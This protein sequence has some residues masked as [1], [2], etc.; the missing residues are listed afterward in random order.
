MAKRG[1]ISPRAVATLAALSLVFAVVVFAQSATK[2]RTVPVSG[3]MSH[4]FSGAEL[5]ENLCA[6]CH[7]MDGRGSGPAAAALKDLPADLTRLSR[8]EGG[9]FPMVRVKRTIEGADA[10]MAHGSREMPIWGPI[11]QSLSA[12]NPR[13]VELRVSNLAKHIETM[14]EK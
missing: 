4:V 5:Y 3:E 6:V 1:P 8:Q 9:K 14:Q 10:I 7:G 11:F 12:T 2:I 13:L